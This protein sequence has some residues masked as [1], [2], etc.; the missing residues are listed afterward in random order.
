MK[1]SASAV[2]LVLIAGC[3]PSTGGDTSPPKSPEHAHGAGHHGPPAN[4]PACAELATKCHGRDEQGGVPRECHLLGHSP[5][6]TNEQC[7]ARRAECLAA[8]EAATP[9]APH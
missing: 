6:A 7:E 5:K 3:G 2:F 9:S 8:C 4:G 1:L